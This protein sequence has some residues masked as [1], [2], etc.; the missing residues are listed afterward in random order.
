L[1]NSLFHPYIAYSILNWGRA[2]NAAVQPLIK[3]Q[4]KTNKTN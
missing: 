4:N 1:S 3:L 2:S